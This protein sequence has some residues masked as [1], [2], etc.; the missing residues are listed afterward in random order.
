MDQKIFSHWLMTILNLLF[1][2]LSIFRRQSSIYVKSPPLCVVRVRIVIHLNATERERWAINSNMIG[3][4]TNDTN[5][6]VFGYEAWCIY[7]LFF[8]FV[9][10]E[11]YN[12]ISLTEPN[13]FKWIEWWKSRVDSVGSSHFLRGNYKGKRKKKKGRRVSRAM[14]GKCLSDQ[15]VVC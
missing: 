2:L 12:K 13:N 8:L 10:I 7:R 9:S 4:I 11:C 14:D 6:W 5:F 1:T 15:Q 3:C